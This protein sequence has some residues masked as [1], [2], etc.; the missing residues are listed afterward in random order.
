M[1]PR[2]S[3]FSRNHGI[4][5]GLKPENPENLGLNQDVHG[6]LVGLNHQKRDSNGI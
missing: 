4:L 6:I 3:E 2:T 1:G 5:M